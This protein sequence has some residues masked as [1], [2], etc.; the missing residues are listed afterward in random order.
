MFVRPVQRH[1]QIARPRPRDDSPSRPRPGRRVPVRC[2]PRWRRSAARAAAAP[3]GRTPDSSS[4]SAAKVRIVSSM[5]NRFRSLP[6][7]TTTQDESTSRRIVAAA[8]CASTSSTAWT[9][10]I[11]NWPAKT[12]S[13]A[14]RRCCRGSAG[15]SSPGARRPG[16][17]RRADRHQ[18]G[19]RPAG[20]R[21]AEV[22]PGWTACL[23]SPRSARSPAAGHRVGGK[24]PRSAC[25]ATSVVWKSGR[26]SRALAMNS[27]T[28]S[29]PAMSA[30]P[31]ATEGQSSGGT[32]QHASPAMPSTTRLVTTILISGT[33]ASSVPASSA[34]C[35]ARRSAPS[36][37]SSLGDR[38]Q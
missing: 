8:V 27:C 33:A 3:P 36:S 4:W 18:A 14:R 21:A 2:P 16:D 35:S 20:G 31:A 38:G 12:L 5:L 24:A 29:E 25:G 10:S 1:V 22:S 37:K 23:P 32:G 26:R 7:V 6:R 9:S 34:T 15:H 28:A 30:A 13:I 11:R 17:V 19:R